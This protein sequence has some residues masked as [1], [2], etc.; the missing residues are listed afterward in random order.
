[1]PHGRLQGNESRLDLHREE[2]I[3]SLANG[4][5]KVSI[6]RRLN[7]SQVNLYHWLKKRKI[8]VPKKR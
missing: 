7:T 4:E 1:L 2:I 8:K 6:A 3:A 5:S